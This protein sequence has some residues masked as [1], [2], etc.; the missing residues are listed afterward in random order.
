MKKIILSLALIFCVQSFAQNTQKRYKYVIVPLQYNFTA[1]PNQFQLNVLTRVML[2]QEG[3]EVFMSEGE[4]IPE[5]VANN[6]CSTLKADVKKDR[7]ILT[8][9]LR[10]QLFNCYGNLVFESTGTSREKAFDDSYKE[11]L[12]MAI[13]EFQIES[14]KYISRQTDEEESQKSIEQTEE[15]P[16]SFEERATKFT[17]GNN[18]LWMV[19]EGEDYLL[20]ND[21]GETVWATLKFADKGTYS[22]DSEYIDGAAYFTPEGDIVVEYLAKNKDAVQKMIIARE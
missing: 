18:A 20:Y 21:M 14:Y 19:K 17:E 9:N 13:R 11:A 12:R 15:T 5:Y 22:F 16:L 2:Q 3:F 8:S 4:E 1:K 7:S 6:P 10:F